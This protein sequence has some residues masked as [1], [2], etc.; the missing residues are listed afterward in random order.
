[1]K[2]FEKRIEMLEREV[3]PSEK[4]NISQVFEKLNKGEEVSE[5]QLTPAAL[6]FLKPLLDEQ[7]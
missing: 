3:N 4:L 7:K 1:L 5:E 6:N 2:N